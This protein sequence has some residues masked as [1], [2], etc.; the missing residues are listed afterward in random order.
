[1]KSLGLGLIFHRQVFYLLPTLS[2]QHGLCGHCE[3][4][5]WNLSLSFLFWSLSIQWE[6]HE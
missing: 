5:H 6:A 4:V 3:L 1:M 2:V